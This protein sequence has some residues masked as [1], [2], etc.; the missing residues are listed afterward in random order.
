MANRLHV[1][2][3]PLALAFILSASWAA[4]ARAQGFISPLIGFN[5]VATRRVR[6]SRAAPTS[7]STTASRSEDGQRLRIRRG[8]RLRQDFFGTA[9]TM[10]SSVLNRDEQPDARPAKSGPSARTE[11]FGFGL[12]KTHVELTPASC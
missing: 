6:T 7:G 1:R 9:P 11:S 2:L 4:T 10:S 3:F 12:I 5:F 8:V